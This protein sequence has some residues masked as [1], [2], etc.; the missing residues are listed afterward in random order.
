VRAL[1][2]P[3][4]AWHWLDPD[5]PQSPWGAAWCVALDDASQARKRLAIAAFAT[6]TGDIEQ[7]N[8]EPILSEQV[9]ARF[10]RFYEVFIE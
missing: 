2:Y 1:Q 4:W 10:R 8:C 9:T 3:I 7:L 6:Q 5:M